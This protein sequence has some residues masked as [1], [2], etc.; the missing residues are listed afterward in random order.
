MILGRSSKPRSRASIACAGCRAR[1]TKCIID[2]GQSSCDRCIRLSKPCVL[3]DDDE[4]KRPVTKAQVHALIRRIGALEQRLSDAGL[5]IP[6]ALT[7][8]GSMAAAMQIP[9]DQ[10][11][12]GDD[13]LERRTSMRDDVAAAVQGS[14]VTAAALVAAATG[15]GRGVAQ[16][17]GFRRDGSRDMGSS[18][19]PQD[20]QSYHFRPGPTLTSSTNGGSGPMWPPPPI[21]ATTTQD[22]SKIGHATDSTANGS[23]SGSRTNNNGATESPASTV[24]SSDM[25]PSALYSESDQRRRLRAGSMSNMGPRGHSRYIG[26]T[27]N[28]HIYSNMYHAEKEETR[29]ER[30]KNMARTREFLA[31]IPIDAHRH[32][33]N[34]FWSCYNTIIHIVHRRAFELDSGMMVGGGSGSGVDGHSTDS[35]REPEMVPGAG[36]S[37]TSSGSYYSPF[38][39]MCML[40]VGYRYADRT[41]PDV[42]AFATPD[43]ESLLHEEAKRLVDSELQMPGG[44]PSLQALLLLGDL[45]CGVGRYNTGWLYAGMACR[46]IFDLGLNRQIGQAGQSRLDMEV[47]RT[48]LWGC[49]VLDRFWGLFLGRPTSIKIADITISN[50]PT[51]PW[52]MRGCLPMGPKFRFETEIYDALIHLT[53]TASKLTDAAHWHYTTS[54][55][56]AYYFVTGLHHELRNWHKQLSSRLQW[57]PANLARDPPSAFFNLH[58][59][60]HTMYILMYRPFLSAGQ[61]TPAGTHNTGGGQTNGNTEPASSR[62]G[63]G[64][65]SP[66]DD[67]IDDTGP[68]DDGMEPE[69]GTDIVTEMARRMC[70]THAIEVARIY[71]AFCARFECRS[72]FVT[73]MQHAATTAF[74]IVEGLSTQSADKQAEALVHLQRLAESL[75]AHATVYYPA[76]VMSNILFRVLG[77]Y[78]DSHAQRQ[79]NQHQHFRQHQHQH[80]Q[81]DSAHHPHHIHH[82]SVDMPDAN[83]AAPTTMP[84]AWTTT[85]TSSGMMQPPPV[86]GQAPTT[87]VSHP[88]WTGGGLQGTMLDGSIISGAGAN[89]FVDFEFDSGI[90]ESIMNTLSQPLDLGA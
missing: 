12:Y 56:S 1:R 13:P 55:P 21:Q 20:P 75:Y 7:D 36:S 79:A 60:Y 59:Q 45:E 22:R 80:Q 50:G 48:V 14:V 86:P 30:E 8:D 58:Q 23:F 62:G 64:S 54:D 67:V 34:Q 85:P 9:R 66:Y 25:A 31:N 72:M 39:H 57:T 43:G 73:G 65:C 32:L 47:K 18:S 10:Q 6:P 87:P 3:R 77:E 16:A 46:L 27:T 19:P 15:N 29:R 78:R 38:L 71:E 82:Q 11:S 42:Q 24:G 63:G 53:D 76:R 28:Y 5:E 70:F 44:I 17:A 40:S 88:D 68:T 41:R 51:Q 33:I 83:T 37:N 35:H 61:A 2:E 4:R 90:W 69:M 49:V 84:P 89:S 74:A 81:Q 52:P 26:I